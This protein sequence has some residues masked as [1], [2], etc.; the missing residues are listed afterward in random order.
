MCCVEVSVLTLNLDDT[1]QRLDSIFTR[2]LVQ[3]GLGQ[4]LHLGHNRWLEDGTYCM[5][6]HAHMYCM[7][8]HT[9][10]HKHLTSIPSKALTQASEAS[11]MALRSCPPSRA[12]TT[13]PPAS[14]I[15]CLVRKPKPSRKQHTNTHIHRLRRIMTGQGFCLDI[16]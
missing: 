2:L 16:A 15:S 8:M 10:T 3:H 9:H 13:R 14:D 7:Y 6:L 4:R 1:L 5:S 11:Q 12:R